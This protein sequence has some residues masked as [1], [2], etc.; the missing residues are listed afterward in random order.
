MPDKAITV[1]IVGKMSKAG[2]T[3]TVVAGVGVGGY[4]W[5]RHKKSAAATA[6]ASTSASGSGSATTDT[7]GNTGNCDPTTDP[8]CPGYNPGNSDYG[9]GYGPYGL[10]DY[11]DTGGVAGDSGY[12]GAGTPGVYTPVNPQATTNAQWSQAAVSALTNAGYEG[13]TV[14][15]ALGV[16]LTGGTLSASQETIVNAAI[17]AEGYPPVEGPNGY[18]PSMHHTTST[19][20]SGGTT[21]AGP[22]TSAPAGLTAHT[23][24]GDVTVA[25]HNV[26][27]ADEFN[28]HFNNGHDVSGPTPR[29]VFSSATVGRSGSVKV[30]AGNAQ[31]WGPWSGSVNFRF[32]SPR[33]PGGGKPGTAKSPGE[34]E[35]N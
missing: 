30:R 1:P 11:S 29:G 3:V 28:F 4:I 6:A 5:W 19:G 17:A 22:P 35:S 27:G 16:Y 2:L 33:K 13:D 25:C 31:G 7:S 15:A 14:L 20:Q 18:P 8:N 9:Y 32:S 12:Y 34:S 26:P 10:G 24:G 23:S 21:P